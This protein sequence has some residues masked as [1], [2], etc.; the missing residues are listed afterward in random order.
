MGG[1]VAWDTCPPPRRLSWGR[2]VNTASIYMCPDIIVSAMPRNHH[3]GITVTLPPEHLEVFF[4]PVQLR[5]L[6]KLAS[7]KELTDNEKRYLRG[8]LGRKLSALEELAGSA[9]RESSDISGLARLL[10]G[11]GEYYITGWEALKHN[12]FGWYFDIR[13]LDVVSTRLDG[14]LRFGGRHIRFH[15]VR[16]AGKGSWVADGDTGL[17]YATN[18]RLL[19]DAGMLGDA[20]L[21]RAWWSMLERYGKL[22]VGRPGRFT[23]K[24]PSRPG[25]GRPEDYGV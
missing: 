21:V 8:N 25:L 16:S 9:S 14:S 24:R 4:K 22:F 15:R 13:R 6:R 2:H 17:R 3:P 1:K 10:R 11:A 12:G 23:K 18:E 20:E 7:G 5:V 19:R